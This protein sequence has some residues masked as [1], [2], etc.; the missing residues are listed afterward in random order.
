M[1]VRQ[2]IEKLKA[3]PPD[4]EVLIAQP[5]A[6]IA[7]QVVDAARMLVKN[8]DTGRRKGAVIIFMPEYGGGDRFEF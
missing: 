2:L 4:Q 3:L 5:E 7:F 8:T 1:K 6:D